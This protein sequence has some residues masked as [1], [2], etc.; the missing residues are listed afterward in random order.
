MR[1]LFHGGVPGLKVGSVIIPGMAEHRY[2]E[3]CAHCEAQRRG[4]S[5][6][7]PATPEGWVYACADLPYARYYASRAVYGSL[8]RVR[9]EGDV[10]PS[11]EDPSIFHAY[12]ARS[13]V[14][15][16]VLENRIL[17]TMKERFKLWKRWGGTEAEFER[18]VSS[19]TRPA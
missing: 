19:M 13:A 14:V 4:S 7:D 1:L 9:L 10:E 12:R 2:V 5:V 18:M 11:V 15:V 8:Y 3:G 6:G 17:L 16:Q